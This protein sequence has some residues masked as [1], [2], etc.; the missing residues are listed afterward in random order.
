[1]INANF[2]TT[3]LNS[4]QGIQAFYTYRRTLEFYIEWKMSGYP[5]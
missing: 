2:R 5:D 4:I 3:N 1:M